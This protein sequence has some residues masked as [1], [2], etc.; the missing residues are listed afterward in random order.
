MPNVL[1]I[2]AVLYQK[3]SRLGRP[4]LQNAHRGYL[5]QNVRRYYTGAEVSTGLT[6]AGLGQNLPTPSLKSIVISLGVYSPGIILPVQG[7]RSKRS[8][9]STLHQFRNQLF[10]VVFQALD[11]TYPAGIGHSFEREP[12]VF[13]PWNRVRQGGPWFLQQDVGWYSE[14]VVKRPGH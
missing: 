13:K 12:G 14:V 3:V 10:R 1:D 5:A 4:I 11:V 7:C 2:D 8:A 6:L 9:T